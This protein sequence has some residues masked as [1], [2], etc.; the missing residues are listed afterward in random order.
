MAET[1][2]KDLRGLSLFLCEQTIDRQQGLHVRFA[3]KF[4][5]MGRRMSRSALR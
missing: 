4:A 3:G 2:A 1:S 5:S